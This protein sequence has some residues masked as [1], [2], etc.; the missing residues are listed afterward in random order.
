MQVATRSEHTLAPD[1]D[2]SAFEQRMTA[3]IKR[4]CEGDQSSDDESEL[5]TG[6]WSSWNFSQVGTF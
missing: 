3:L 6:S 4:L 2:L 5:E 1:K